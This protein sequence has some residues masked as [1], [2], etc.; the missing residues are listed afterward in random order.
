MATVSIEI[1]FDDEH[2]A[3]ETRSF[4]IDPVKIPLTMIEGMADANYGMVRRAIT[5]FLRLTPAQSEQLTI[6]NLNQIAEAAKNAQ[7]IPNGIETR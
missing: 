5:R 1:T 4:P 7:T 3:P 2:G 6:E